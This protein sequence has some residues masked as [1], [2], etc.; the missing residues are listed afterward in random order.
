MPEK[1]SS[2]VVSDKKY[3]TL[4]IK[5]LFVYTAQ[6]PSNYTAG[7]TKQKA[8]PKQYVEKVSLINFPTF[9]PDCP[10]IGHDICT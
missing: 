3:V 10:L 9:F 6:S 4:S 1:V 8:L 7:Q 5:H 2:K